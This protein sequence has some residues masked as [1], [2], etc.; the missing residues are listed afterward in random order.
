MEWNGYHFGA[1][2]L[3]AVLS[4]LPFLVAVIGGAI[5]YVV[6]ERRDKRGS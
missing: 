4:I 6:E 2:A 1:G 5:W 3:L